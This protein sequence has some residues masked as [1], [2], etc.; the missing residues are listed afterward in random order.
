METIYQRI[1]LGIQYDGSKYSG[2]Q[3]QPHG[4]TIQDQLENALR[5]FIGQTDA[6]SFS[7]VQVAGRTDAGVHAIGQVVHFDAPVNRP[8]WSWVR[9]LNTYLP[10]DISVHWAKV[11][12]QDFDA[13]FSAVE[14]AYVYHLVGAPFPLPLLREK[15]GWTL[16]PPGRQLNIEAMKKAAHYLIGEH[17]FSSFRSSECQS[18]TPV[19]TLYQLDIIAEQQSVYFF[20]RGNAFLH[21]MVRNIVGC[22]LMVGQN[23]HPAQWLKEV[24]EERDRQ[25]A[26]PTFFP[27]GLYLA[28]VGYPPEFQIP[29]PLW[30]VAPL[31]GG[32][33]KGAFGRGNWTSNLVKSLE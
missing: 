14:R 20:V 9:G 28:R 7:R 26:A 16:L 5:T 24:L 15:A 1:A 13:R 21:H 12:P 2:W 6:S 11:V 19:K 10:K 3:S 29:E 22:L 27:D 32:L 31:N 8:D 4:N 17:D 30:G 18:K 33:L 23:K 25:K